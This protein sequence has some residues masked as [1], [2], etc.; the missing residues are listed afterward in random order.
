MEH[1]EL[2]DLRNVALTC[3]FLHDFVTSFVKVKMATR[4]QWDLFFVLHI[5]FYLFQHKAVS[6]QLLKTFQDFMAR[7]GHLLTSEEQQFF[8]NL[9]EGRGQLGK[10][11]GTIRMSIGTGFTTSLV[12]FRQ[13]PR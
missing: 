11:F 3:R 7:N 13:V 6:Y 10:V 1:L 8:E 2:V 4:I 5:S 12:T 9:K